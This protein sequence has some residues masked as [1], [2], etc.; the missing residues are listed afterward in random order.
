MLEPDQTL[1]SAIGRLVPPWV[2][3]WRMFSQARRNAGQFLRNEFHYFSGMQRLI[4]L[5]Y[6][7]IL[8]DTPPPIEL[9]SIQRVAD[10]MDE[11]F[12]QVP[13]KEALP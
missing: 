1:P 2:Q 10:W 7:S 6:R 11:I 4:S 12:R 8:E 3:G 9:A 5:F 13:Q